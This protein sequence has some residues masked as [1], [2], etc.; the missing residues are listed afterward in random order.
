MYE[1]SVII[2]FQVLTE[3]NDPNPEQSLQD[4][5]ETFKTVVPT[6]GDSLGAPVMQIVTSDG[7]V[8][9][10]EGF[11]DLSDLDGNTGFADLINRF[12]GA[13]NGVVVEETIPLWETF[14]DI[15]ESVE[16]FNNPKPV[17]DETAD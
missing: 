5:E 13:G 10:S 1:G 2:E 9:S 16:D 4:I 7:N 6:L 3:E 15:S 8:V 11:E 17:V 14:D 12:G